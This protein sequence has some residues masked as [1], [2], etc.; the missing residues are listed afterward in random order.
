MLSLLEV[1]LSVLSMSSASSAAYAQAHNHPWLSAEG[2]FI[3][4][5]EAIHIVDTHSIYIDLPGCYIADTAAVHIQD[6]RNIYAVY[7]DV[8]ISALSTDEQKV[9]AYDMHLF[10]QQISNS[11][12]ERFT[13]SQNKYL[14]HPIRKIPEARVFITKVQASA[15]AYRPMWPIP[16]DRPTKRKENA[17]VAVSTA[18]T[19]SSKSK[20]NQHTLFAVIVP[21]R[22]GQRSSTLRHRT[23]ISSYQCKTK[24]KD[25]Y[26]SR[27]VLRGPPVIRFNC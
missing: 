14:A 17:C 26:L 10:L 2:V 27:S 20:L 24:Y 12:K 4:D 22:Y 7:Q 18:A 25:I 15:S 8:Y 6:V 21:L 16:N 23:R 9:R 13:K 19:P 5:T 3:A 11:S 1:V